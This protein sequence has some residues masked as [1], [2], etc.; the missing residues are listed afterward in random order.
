M[1][2]LAP[3]LPARLHRSPAL[4]R[5]AWRWLVPTLGGWFPGHDSPE[6]S[7]RLRGEMPRSAAF[8]FLAL[9]KLGRVRV[10]P[11]HLEALSRLLSAGDF[12]RIALHSGQWEGARAP[13]HAVSDAPGDRPEGSAGQVYVD[14]DYFNPSH[15]DDAVSAP[16]FLHP[17]YYASGLYRDV[18]RYRRLRRPI[19]LF[20]AGTLDSSSYGQSFASGLFK[21]MNRSEVL[22]TVLEEFRDET[23][24]IR[25]RGELGK[26]RG[27]KKPIVLILTGRTED[28]LTKHVLRPREYLRVLA[29]SAFALCPPGWIMPHCH[30]L[31]EAL[32]VGVA[33][34][35][36]YGKYFDPPLVNGVNSIAFHD[37]ASLRSAVGQALTVPADSVAEYATAAAEYYDEVMSVDAFAAQLAVALQSGRQVRVRLNRGEPSVR[38]RESAV[39]S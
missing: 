28:N 5:R 14:Y 22:T 26:L 13:R 17:H 8:L 7:V 37:R 27:N 16:F 39:A 38:L 10:W 2:Y 29:R 32:A 21:M 20:F 30:N 19:R 31:V 23:L 24:V 18:T 35:L 36:S 25:R 34:I 3:T 6:F 33:P 15:D 1:H 4:L 9:R 12:F 11:G